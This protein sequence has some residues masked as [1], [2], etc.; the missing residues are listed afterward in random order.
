MIPGRCFACHRAVGLSSVIPNS[1]ILDCSSC[2]SA[3]RCETWFASHVCRKAYTY[4]ST[5]GSSRYFE[6]GYD[7]MFSSEGCAYYWYALLCFFR[8]LVWWWC[9]SALLCF[10]RLSVWWRCRFALLCFLR[11]SIWWRCRFA[12]LYFLRLSVRWRCRFALLCFL[13]LLV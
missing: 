9:R 3:G 1:T 6:Y 11:L 2:A 8:L 13:R 10:L 12:L 4:A 7:M 5:Y